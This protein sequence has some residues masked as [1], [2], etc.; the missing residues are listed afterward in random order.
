MWTGDLKPVNRTDNPAELEVVG[1]PEIQCLWARWGKRG[2]VCV[3]VGGG[4]GGEYLI[5]LIFL[6]W[7]YCASWL[8]FQRRMEEIYDAKP[9]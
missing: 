8:N 4:G 5:K 2:C 1:F 7:K 9:S 3:C 6:L